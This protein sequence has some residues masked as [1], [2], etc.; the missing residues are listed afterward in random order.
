MPDALFAAATRRT[1]FSALFNPFRERDP[2]CDLPHA[3]RRRR[4]NLAR[5]FTALDAL[6]GPRD[7]WLAEA[8]GATGTRRT[9]IPLVDERELALA[10]AHYAIGPPLERVTD[11]PLPAGTSPG[12]AIW[13]EIVRTD[14][15]PVLWNVLLHHPERRV[16]GRLTNRAPRAGEVRYFTPMI[17]MA[18]RRWCVGEAGARPPRVIA[19]GKFAER[20]ALSLKLPGVTY[21]RHPAQGGLTAFRDGMAAL[22]AG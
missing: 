15:R 14:Y 3:A 5:Y 2:T 10:N 21:V 22:Y 7:L 4:D 17:E 20:A 1:P 19:I 11:G 9:G 16:G 12:R 8:P 6:D 13:A 18:Y